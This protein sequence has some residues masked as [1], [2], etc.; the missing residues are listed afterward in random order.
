MWKLPA[1][2]LVDE[3][4]DATVPIK[5]AKGCQGQTGGILNHGKDAEGAEHRIGKPNVLRM[6]TTDEKPIKN[7]T[8]IKDAR[9]PVSE[10]SG[11]LNQGYG[12]NIK[13][14]TGGSLKGCGHGYPDG[15]G[16]Y[17][18]DPGHPYQPREGAMT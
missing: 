8:P 18:C 16:C 3:I 13:A 6:P 14:A 1:V 11:T 17:L 5:D 15:K 9:M 2:D 4:K 12:R 10:N 7:A